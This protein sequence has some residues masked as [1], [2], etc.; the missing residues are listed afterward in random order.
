MHMN[1]DEVVN[2]QN[3]ELLYFCFVPCKAFLDNK[4][5]SDGCK[6]SMMLTPA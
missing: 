3:N 6:I 2:F 1:E 4:V 5:S